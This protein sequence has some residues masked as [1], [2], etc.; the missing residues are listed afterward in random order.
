MAVRAQRDQLV[1]R[2]N[3]I[4]S[5]ECSQWP[6]RVHTWPLDVATT[7]ASP[8]VYV[9]AGVVALSIL[10]ILHHVLRLY[11]PLKFMRKSSAL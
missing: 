2:V 9:L 8:S 11:P 6:G 4:I 10:L 5:H 3:L 7:P 1:N